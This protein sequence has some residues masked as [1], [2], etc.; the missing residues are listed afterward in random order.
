MINEIYQF[1]LVVTNKEDIPGFEKNPGTPAGTLG[2][3]EASMKYSGDKLLVRFTD[4]NSCVVPYA[5]LQVVACERC[6]SNHYVYSPPNAEKIIRKIRQAGDSSICEYIPVCNDCYEAW[7]FMELWKFLTDGEIPEGVH[8]PDWQPVSRK[9]ATSILWLL[10]EHYQLMADNFDVCDECEEPF[11]CDAESYEATS[12]GTFCSD[13][14]RQYGTYCEEC[15]E[16][17]LYGE[18]NAEGQCAECAGEANGGTDENA[19]QVAE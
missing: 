14:K 18:L 1:G 11:D 7:Q 15:G 17:N 2:I 19:S 12:V 13:C 9:Q 16:F 8:I 10:Q 3:V 4:W 6:S 5:A